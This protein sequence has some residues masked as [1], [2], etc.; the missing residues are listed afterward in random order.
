[1]SDWWGEGPEPGQDDPGWWSGD[2][3]DDDNAPNAWAKNADSDAPYWV[4]PDPG[5]VEQ[6]VVP[7]SML[8]TAV[9]PTVAPPTTPP[10]GPPPSASAVEPSPPRNRRT[11]RRG[12]FRERAKR[13]TPPVLL[14]LAS[15]AL[16]AGSIWKATR[17]DPRPAAAVAALAEAE[18]AQP[19]EREDPIDVG[20]QTIDLP[21][22]RGSTKDEALAVL[23]EA[24]IAAEKIK[25]E[26]IDWAG[27]AGKVVKQDPPPGTDNP[28]AVTIEIAAAVGAPEVRGK[29]EQEAI[30]S[31]EALGSVAEVTR[32]YVPGG[33]I[34]TVVE[35]SPDPNAPLTEASE[36]TV[37]AEG[38][39][40]PIPNL[41]PTTNDCYTESVSIAGTSYDSGLS[42]STGS[43]I[44]TFDANLGGEFGEFST[45]L[46]LP[47]GTQAGTTLTV[48]ISDGTTTLLTQPVSVGQN[49]QIKV[50]LV[51]KQRLMITFA[52][53]TPTGGSAQVLLGDPVV[54]ADASVADRFN[55]GN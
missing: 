46:G 51:G 24:G 33:T 16:L 11:E 38:V 1:M 45:V 18:P 14:L 34:G 21:D 4:D 6:G 29:T 39:P 36:V 40:V 52:G 27:T 28:D 9:S 50:P 53:T 2:E 35:Q 8:P 15:L 42:C 17:P 37:A 47:D 23:T 3:P 5:T 54:V 26:T 10:L 55:G 30:N 48:T 25:A 43:T 31:L 19:I 22:V 41:S 7:T 20:K 13:A 12:Q 49:G 32:K 44:T